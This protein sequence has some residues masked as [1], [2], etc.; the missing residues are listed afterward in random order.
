MMDRLRNALGLVAAD[1]EHVAI[2]FELSQ[3]ERR[4]LETEILLLSLEAR[5]ATLNLDQD[6][7]D[8]RA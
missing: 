4:Q 2:E 6:V 8:E 7:A 5:V 3:L 1:H